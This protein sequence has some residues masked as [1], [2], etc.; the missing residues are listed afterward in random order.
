MSD[1]GVI[2]CAVELMHPD[3]LLSRHDEVIR[4]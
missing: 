3:R 1:E 2:R 4:K